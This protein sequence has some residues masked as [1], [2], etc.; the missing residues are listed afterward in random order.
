MWD[1]LQEQI[2]LDLKVEKIY[3]D[4]L[5]EPPKLLLCQGVVSQF[6]QERLA[7]GGKRKLCFDATSEHHNA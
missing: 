5:P 7:V 6:A 4:V 2:Y 1:P 3:R